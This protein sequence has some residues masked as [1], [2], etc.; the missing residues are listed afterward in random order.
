MIINQYPIH[1]VEEFKLACEKLR[2]ETDLS[3]IN[4]HIAPEKYINV[5]VMTDGIPLIQQDQLRA[6]IRN[7]VKMGEGDDQ[8]S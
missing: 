2:K 4:L 1:T 6:V 3:H 8:D 5:K 7:I